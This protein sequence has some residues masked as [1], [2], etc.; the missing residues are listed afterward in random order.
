VD[1]GN[2]PPAGPE[3][4]QANTPP[5]ALHAILE[6]LKRQFSLV[7]TTDYDGALTQVRADVEFRSGNIWALIF[8]ILIASVGLNVNSTAVIIG[9]MLISPLMGP[10]VAAGFGLGTNDIPL[11][12]RSIRNLLVATVVALMA[13][14]LYFLV[15]PLA[16]AQSELLARTR[17]TL[18]DVLIAFFG[19]GAGAVAVTRRNNKGNVMPGVAIATALMPPLCTAGFGLATGNLAYF[20]GAMHLYLINTLFICLATLGFVRLMG[21]RRVAELGRG[22]VKRARVIILVLTLAIVVPSGI[23]GWHVVKEAGFKQRARKFVETHISFPDRTLLNLELHYSAKGSTIRATLLGETLPKETQRQ[24]ESQLV[25]SGLQ[26]TRLVLV[27]PEGSGMQVEELGIAV[28]QGIIEDLYR[29][30]EETLGERDRR[31]RELEKQLGGAGLADRKL[32]LLARELA[33]LHPGLV[34]LGLG[35]ELAP[36]RPDSLATPV[37]LAAWTRNPE[38][39][40]RQR[41]EQFLKVRLEN[42]SL[43]VVHDV[44]R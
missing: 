15:S 33:A 11:L 9:A 24:L 1:Y 10:I 37:V 8:A 35:R 39:G 12:K 21:F 2:T 36:G 17:P 4:T 38:T 42:D 19:G 44:P 16:D 18:Y 22:H 40:D 25:A 26:D 31:I 34:S 27:Q 13:S 43:R 20:L 7:P 29:R 23:T 41:L 32:G 6:F 3:A 28:R 5:D 14:T 30:N